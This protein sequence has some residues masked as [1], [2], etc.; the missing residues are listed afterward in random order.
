M[1]VWL[2]HGALGW[3]DEIIFAGVAI[4]F[5]VMMGVSWVRSRTEPPDL[6]AARADD[7]APDADSPGPDG[8]P[9]DRFQLD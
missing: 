1:P 8:D 5:L 4:I 7:P 6:D 2:A 9:S 3:W